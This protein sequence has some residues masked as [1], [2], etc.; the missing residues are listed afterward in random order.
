MIFFCIF[1]NSNES[2]TFTDI[3]NQTQKPS[4][5]TGNLTFGNFEFSS[6]NDK[7]EYEI[8][9]ELKLKVLKKFKKETMLYINKNCDKKR[10]IKIKEITN[11]I[12]S[13]EDY[14][15]KVIISCYFKDELRL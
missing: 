5:K 12:N 14:S 9:N 1:S 3:F 4:C 8:I 10:S 15:T 13:S 7:F 11:Y 6:K 2:C